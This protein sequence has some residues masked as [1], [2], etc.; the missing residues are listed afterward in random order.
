[1][2]TGNR[3]LPRGSNEHAIF[4]TSPGNGSVSILGKNLVTIPLLDI[5]M[6]F[7]EFSEILLENSVKFI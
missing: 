2:V 6:N 4:I 7:T 3:Y 1:M 5:V